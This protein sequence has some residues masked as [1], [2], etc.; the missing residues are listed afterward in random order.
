MLASMRQY[1]VDGPT[2]TNAAKGYFGVINLGNRGSSQNVYYSC[3]LDTGGNVYAIGTVTASGSGGS[4]TIITKFGPDSTIQWQNSY[5]PYTGSTYTGAPIASSGS[6]IKW[7]GSGNVLIAATVG[8]GVNGGNILL[9]KLNQTTGSTVWAKTLANINTSINGVASLAINT[10][11]GT[12]YAAFQNQ[13]SNPYAYVIKID[14]ITGVKYW[15]MNSNIRMGYITSIYSGGTTATDTV[16]ILG[17]GGTDTGSRL[18]IASWSTGSNAIP[19]ATTYW[20]QAN[21]SETNSG[22]ITGPVST[23]NYY[24]T[25]GNVNGYQCLT[26]INTNGPTAWS[27]PFSIGGG[28]IAPGFAGYDSIASN[29]VIISQP[30]TGS[31][32]LVKLNTA[33]T[34][35]YL[36]SNISPMGAGYQYVTGISAAAVRNGNVAVVGQNTTNNGYPMVFKNSTGLTTVSNTYSVAGLNITYQKDTVYNTLSPARP[37]SITLLSPQINRLIDTT[38]LTNISIPTGNLQQYVYS[39]VQTFTP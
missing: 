17:S 32:D 30:S 1:W 7:D 5:S 2:V 28:T 18:G 36:A 25:S 29:I 27:R 35:A 22:Q 11:A 23:S 37:F 20:G 12:C 13:V 39:S 38:A 3:D 16:T 10:T 31:M 21:I 14:P 4:W 9:M 6:T 24:F 26:S 15:S 19:T 33:G 34:T 8:A